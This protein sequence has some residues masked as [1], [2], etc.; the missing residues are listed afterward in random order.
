MTGDER[1]HLREIRAARA[2]EILELALHAAHLATRG[3]DDALRFGLRLADDEPRLALG[4]L[5][6]LLAHLLRGD[7]RLVQRAIALAEGAELLVERA[8]LLVEVLIDA[9]EAF[10]L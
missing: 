9:R 6:R 2:L 7:E 4:L 5:A 8:R 3:L 1:A 10:H